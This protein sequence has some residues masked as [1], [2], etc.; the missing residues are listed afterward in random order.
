MTLVSRSARV[1]DLDQFF[2]ILPSMEVMPFCGS[3]FSA[4]IRHIISFVMACNEFNLDIS[5]DYGSKTWFFLFVKFASRCLADLQARI[6]RISKL[7]LPDTLDL[8][9]H[10]TCLQHLLKRNL[11]FLGCHREFMVKGEHLESI[12]QA[13]ISKCIPRIE[14]KNSLECAQYHRLVLVLEE[15]FRVLDENNKKVVELQMEIH[16]SIDRLQRMER[17]EWMLLDEI[18]LLNSI[19]RMRRTIRLMKIMSIMRTTRMIRMMR[20]REHEGTVS[21]ARIVDVKGGKSME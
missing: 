13:V 21:S 6:K 14:L 10:L 2:G 20:M 12:C 15:L 18:T 5:N 8:L 11:G 7:S 3:L 19:R 1:I 16:K 4:R 9:I 17:M